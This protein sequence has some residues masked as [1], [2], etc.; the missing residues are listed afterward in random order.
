MLT[1]LCR[2]LRFVEEVLQLK[3]TSL[4]TQAADQNY[5]LRGAQTGRAR[6]LNVFF[7]V[8]SRFAG[9]VNSDVEEWFVRPLEL[10]SRA[11]SCFLRRHWL[12]IVPDRLGELGPDRQ[13]PRS[14]GDAG[15]AFL[16]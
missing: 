1:F 14:N 8:K 2:S 16:S 15:S 12:G 7:C 3:C 9:A 4:C 5:K 13:R 11:S 6:L 10:I